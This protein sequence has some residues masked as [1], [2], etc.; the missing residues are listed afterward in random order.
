MYVYAITLYHT[1][2]CMYMQFLLNI[3]RDEKRIVPHRVFALLCPACKSYNAR[4]TQ[5]P[6]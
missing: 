1:Y 2:V 5:L 4:N 3:K 6:N